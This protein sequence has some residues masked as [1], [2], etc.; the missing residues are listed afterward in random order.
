VGRPLKKTK[1]RPPPRLTQ[2]LLESRCRYWQKVLGLSDWTI[3]A[4]LVRPEQFANEDEGQIGECSALTQ[5]RTAVVRVIDPRHYPTDSLWPQD[6]EVIL[7][8]ELIH[9]HFEP[10]YKDKG[11]LNVVQEQ[12]IQALA[13]GYLQVHRAK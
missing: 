5:N 8:H 11:L 6:W 1:G 4:E 12:A 13:V 9:C 10:F 3:R 2:A 7:V